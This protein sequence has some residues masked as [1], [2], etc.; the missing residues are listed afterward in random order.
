MRSKGVNMDIEVHKDYEQIDRENIEVFEKTG[1]K[2][3]EE[4]RFTA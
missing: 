3:P 4:D 2:R 1:L